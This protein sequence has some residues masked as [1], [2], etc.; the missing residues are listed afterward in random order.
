MHGRVSPHP[1]NLVNLDIRSQAM[2]QVTGET[3]PAADCTRRLKAAA[4]HQRTENNA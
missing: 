2:V 3:W 4:A 1:V